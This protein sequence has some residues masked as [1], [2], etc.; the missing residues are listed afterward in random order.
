MFPQNKCRRGWPRFAGCAAWPCTLA[1]GFRD[2]S[3]SCGGM[4]ATP[5]RKLGGGGRWRRHARHLEASSAGKAGFRG[6]AP[7]QRPQHLSLRL[8][9]GQSEGHVPWTGRNRWLAPVPGAALDGHCRCPS[10][11]GQATQAAGLPALRPPAETTWAAGWPRRGTSPLSHCPYP[12]WPGQ[13]L[14]LS[15]CK[16]WRQ[17]LGEQ[18]GASTQGKGET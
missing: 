6:S 5:G 7:H 14:C 4:S 12:R 16:T 13:R 2:T 9:H 8:L 1:H 10:L 11:S 3:C 18:L 15:P 17:A